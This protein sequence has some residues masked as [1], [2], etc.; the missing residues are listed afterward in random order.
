MSQSDNR[1]RFSRIRFAA[2]TQ[3]EQHG[4]HW[5]AEL[6]D[7]SL[8][9]ILVAEPDECTIN[10]SDSC[11]IAIVLTGEDTIAMKAN[12]ARRQNQQLGFICREIDVESIAHL[13]R[14]VELN[15][16]DPDAANRELLELVEVNA[17]DQ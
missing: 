2:N 14:L 1:R 11:D 3:I 6:I 7:I 10:A 15:L 16:G 9:G 13:R 4:Q 12:L 17:S 5:T 8:K